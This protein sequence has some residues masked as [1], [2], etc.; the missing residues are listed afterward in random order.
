MQSP[1][2]GQPLPDTIQ[3]SPGLGKEAV[4][5]LPGQSDAGR[6]CISPFDFGCAGLALP[7][8]P[9]LVL[10]HQGHLLENHV[11]SSCTAKDLW[12]QV[13]GFKPQP[14]HWLPV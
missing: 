2:E 12:L 10:P 4:A 14:C 8:A 11:L 9:T 13:P 7:P 3:G 6:N 5:V 1:G